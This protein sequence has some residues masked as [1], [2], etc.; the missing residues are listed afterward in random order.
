[1]CA[2]PAVGDT[3]RIMSANPPEYFTRLELPARSSDR[4][5]TVLSMNVTAVPLA[6]G[7]EQS[8]GAKHDGSS[9]RSGNFS[10]KD[11]LHLALGYLCHWNYN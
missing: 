6:E 2:A 7:V 5:S 10:P 9:L 4:Y 3:S 11:N 1:V 8:T